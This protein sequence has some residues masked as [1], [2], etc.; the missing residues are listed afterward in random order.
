MKKFTENSQ[1]SEGEKITVIRMTKRLPIIFMGIVLIGALGVGACLLLLFLSE[2]LYPEIESLFVSPVW[3]QIY[4]YVSLLSL[5]VGLIGCAFLKNRQNTS[6]AELYVELALMVV[7]F[8][9]MFIF[10]SAREQSYIFN[11]F[12]CVGGAICSVG[13]FCG[14]ASL[15]GYLKKI[16]DNS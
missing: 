15:I 13:F 8:V 3:Y 16:I 9:S 4:I 11:I 14:I 10:A 6:K 5:I 2:T 7:G 1:K 12:M